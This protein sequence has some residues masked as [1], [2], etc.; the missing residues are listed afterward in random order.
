MR[1]CHDNDDNDNKDYGKNDND[2]DE[3]GER[4]FLIRPVRRKYSTLQQVR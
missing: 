2:G 1:W 3:L 4:K